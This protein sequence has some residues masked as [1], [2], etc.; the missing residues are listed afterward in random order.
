MSYKACSS[1]SIL[2]QGVLRTAG[3]KPNTIIGAYKLLT[4]SDSYASKK[5]PW[6]GGPK[7]EGKAAEIAS[8]VALQVRGRVWQNR[9][10][11][12][13]SKS[14]PGIKRQ[15]AQHEGAK[16][17]Q[18]AQLKF[19]A[20]IGIACISCSGMAEPQQRDSTAQSGAQ[21]T[22]QGNT[23]RQ[24]QGQAPEK[25]QN[26]A[27][28]TGDGGKGVTIVVPAP[29]IRD[30]SASD[31]WMPQLFQDAITGDLVRYS[32]MTVID[33]ANEQLVLAEQRISTSG[34]Y[35]DEDYIRIG[36]LTNAQ[37]IVVGKIAK[38]ADAYSVS[39][40]INRTE[41]NEIKTAFDKTY[42]LK[43]IETGLAPKEAARELLIG[44]G[45]QLTQAGERSL[46]AIQETHAQASA[47]LAK[48]M[49][50]EKNGNL[51]EALAHFTEALTADSN[52]REASRHIQNFS[53]SPVSTGSI[54][55]R[56]EYAQAQ[57]QKWEKIFSD[58]KLYVQE[59][60]PIF[61]Y[62]FSIIKDTF[63]ARS[64]RV[65][66]TVSPG[67]KVIPNRTVLMVW[68]TILDNWSEIK[69]REENKTWINAV[70]GTNSVNI[71]IDFSCEFG[72]Y[73]DYGDRIN[74]ARWGKECV[75]RY[76]SSFQALA[77]HKYYENTKFDTFNFYISL[78]KVTDTITPKID[79]V[80]YAAPYKKISYNYPVFTVAE[81]QE[82]LASQG[83]TGN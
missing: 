9:D 5:T 76:S 72:L 2:C 41:T 64:N 32:A 16:K 48:G 18:F 30:H 78:D 21:H 55:E 20:I 36:N 23:A 67:I 63:N 68:K 4:I 79:G 80:F 43:D 46:L 35:S 60:L 54:R 14:M 38:I 50:A 42:S 6:F 28:Y 15:A 25:T 59:N 65:T 51:V 77:Q 3:S 27:P 52:M 49:A 47:Q 33:R 40:R 69:S 70:R 12:R 11:L 81:W 62:D 73:D 13:G 53:G 7:R 26:A 37:Y 66:I 29:V 71:D 39:L 1:L 61:I 57:K 8:S 19:F 22:P 56:A 74:D 83:G 34:N 44:M 31:A 45:V 82:W 24:A 17:F 75:Y 58:L 10:F